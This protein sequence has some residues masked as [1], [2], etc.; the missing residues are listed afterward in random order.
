MPI[1][2]DAGE[3]Y[4]RLARIPTVVGARTSLFVP[5]LDILLLAVRATLTEAAAIW[6]FK[7]QSARA[8][9]I[10]RR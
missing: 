2:H 6:V 10:P 3:R 5:D 1:I 9:P 8:H 4:R 7:P